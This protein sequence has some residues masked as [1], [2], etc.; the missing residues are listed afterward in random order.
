MKMKRFI[1]TL[2]SA[3]MLIS[4]LPVGAF[5][6]EPDTY[7][8]SDGS[9]KLVL[10]SKNGGFVIRTQEGDKLVKSDDNK[11]LLF[12]RDDYDTSFTSFRVTRQ[13]GSYQDYIFGGD[14]GFLGLASSGVTT[15]QDE[16]GLTSVW[17]VDDMTFTQRLELAGQGANEHGAVLLSY[18]AETTSAQPVDVK[19]RLLLDTALGEKDYAYYEV[20]NEFSQYRTIEMETVLTAADHIPQN[21]LGY[22]DPQNP[23]IT[24]YHINVDKAPYQV[25]FGHWNSLGASLF[26]FTPDNSLTF[27]NVYNGKY[28]TADSAVGLY[29]DMGQVTSSA[30]GTCGTYYGVYSNK[31]VADSETIAVNVTAPA[32]LELSA[33][34]KSYL[35]QKDGLLSGVFEMQAQMFNFPS[36]TAKEYDRVT[37]AI[38][39]S[40]GI[41][42]LDIDGN[43]HGT[44]TYLEPFTVDYNGFVVDQ[45]HTGTFRFKAD[46][47]ETSEFRKIELRVFDTSF[48]KTLTT[49]KIIGTKSFYVLCP[50]GDGKLPEVVFTNMSPKIVYNEGQRNLYL[51]G[52]NFGLL[53]DE[54]KYDVRAYSTSDPNLVYDIPDS[55]VEFSQQEGVDTMAVM[56]RETMQPGSYELRFNWLSDPP[57]GVQKDMTAPA[58]S[59]TV[60]EE[61]QYK[62]NYYGIL[63]VAQVGTGGNAEYKI[64]LY[65]TEDEFEKDK[66]NYE[67]ILLTFKGDFEETEEGGKTLYKATS[68]KNNGKAENVVVINDCM[69]FENGVM[70]VRYDNNFDSVLVDFDGDIYTSVKRSKIWSGEASF[71]ELRNNNEYGLVPYNSDGERMEGHFGEPITL[72]WPCGLGIAQSIS[73]MAFNL[74]FGSMGIV[75]DINGKNLSQVTDQTSVLGK[76]VSFSASLDLSFLVPNAGRSSKDTNWASIA[77][78]FGSEMTS[79]ELRNKWTGVNMLKHT[80]NGLN[81]YDNRTKEPQGSV[82]IQ[83][84]LYGCGKGLM[85]LNFDVDLV[86]PGYFDAM[87]SIIGH[88]SVNTI[89]GYE[90][91]AEGIC[92]FGTLEV[93]A[94]INIKDYEGK[95]IPDKLYFAIMGFEPGINVDG[96]G[97]LWITGGGGGID[98]LYDTIFGGSSVP[99]LK[100]LLTVSFD[101]LK[102]MSAKVDL[103]LSLRGLSLSA[104]DVRVKYFDLKVLNRLQ[105]AF[106]WYPEF[107]F[108]ASVDANILSIIR[109]QGYI[110][111][112]N[113]DEYDAFVEFFIR[114]SVQIP[115]AIPIIGGID[116][117][118]ADLGANNEKIWGVVRALGAELGITYYWGGDVDFG[119]GKAVA[120]PSF[121]SL[122]GYEDVPVFYDEETGQTL[123]MRAGSNVN[124][125]AQAYI[126]GEDDGTPKL[127]GADRYIESKISRLAHRITL[128]AFNNVDAALVVSFQADSQEEA[129][130]QAQNITISGKT[131]TFYDKALQN[132][133]SAN[134]NLVYDS[135]N[136]TATVN[137][138]FSEASEFGRSYDMETSVPANLALYDINPMPS[139]NITNAGLSGNVLTVDWD[140]YNLIELDGALFMLTDDPSGSV[141]A[142]TYP[143]HDVSYLPEKTATITLPGDLPTGTYYLKAVYSKE[144]YVNNQI[145]FPTPIQYKNQHQP[146]APTK[147]EAVNGGNHMFD[148]TVDKSVQDDFD[149]Y[150]VNVYQNDASAG[151]VLTDINN[152]VFEKNVDGTMP[153]LEVG[154]Y[155]DIPETDEAGKL[156]GTSKKVGIAPDQEYQIGIK[157]YKS[158]LNGEGKEIGRVLS[159]EVLSHWVTLKAPTPPKVTI[160]N[161]TS[162]Q[163]LYR[164]Q[165]GVAE[166]IPFDTFATGDVTFHVSSDVAVSGTWTLNDSITESIT[167]GQDIV[168]ADLEDGDY[169]LTVKGED[170]DGDT[171]IVEKSFAV[172]TMPPVLLLTSPVNGGLFDTDGSIAITGVTDADAKLTI[173]VN[174]VLY[175]DG[176]TVSELGGTID[177][178]GV[179]T[180]KVPG[181]PAKSVQS[182]VVSAADAMM[183]VSDVRSAKVYN[184]GFAQIDSVSI[185]LDGRKYTS[186]NLPSGNGISGK[187]SLGVNTP[188][189]TFLL[190][191]DDLVDFS[192]Q[193]AEGSASV[194]ANHQLTIDAGSMGTITGRFYVA[195]V[196]QKA[197]K[198]GYTAAIQCSLSFGAEQNELLKD[199]KEVSVSAGTGGA[200]T[201]AGFYTPGDTVVLTA[202]AS[203]GYQFDKWRVTSQNLNLADDKATTISFTMPAE[204]VTLEAIF[205][206][207]SNP[208]NQANSSIRIEGAGELNGREG[209]IYSFNLP[210][211]ANGNNY[212]PYYYENGKKT[213]VR[214]S[215]EVNGRLYFIAPKNA[216]Y[217]LAE[218]KFM[219]QDIAG[220]WA[221]ENILY[222]VSRNIFAGISDTI[223]AP[224]ECMT[225]AMFVTVL[226]R[227]SGVYEDKSKASGFLDV[228]TGMWYTPYVAWAAENGI[229]DGYGDGHFG[230]NDLVTREQMCAIINRYL[231]Q[232]GYNISPSVEAMNFAD[233]AQISPWAKASVI[234]CQTRGLILGKDNGNFAPKDNTT[235][236]EVA[237]LMKRLVAKILE[238]K[239]R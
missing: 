147:V 192:V 134:A 150:I 206:R 111:V 61:K 98:K 158:I 167:S 109:G 146:T 5:A 39:T 100:I 96:F 2:L 78:Q 137:I 73:G 231:E 68:A 57:S 113:N 1:S 157:A 116:V 80:Y 118:G 74:T 55:Q 27:T 125:A 181:D 224:N 126:E 44:G 178:G 101:I 112:L 60:S 196:D 107:Y 92:Q 88:L 204:N 51:T 50:G 12:H 66:G 114:A 229:V 151:A 62:N 85:G 69:D 156:T 184:E 144:D 110:V 16:T 18:K 179:F 20:V 212:A 176:K 138:T 87:P 115:E 216:V 143:I 214:I 54:S 141:S 32:E 207:T 90:I 166:P 93:E 104:T 194:D 173:Y 168:F 165:E 36:D 233:E 191:E 97:V 124:L 225:R 71:S 148:L 219:F 22:N 121:P 43:P 188:T 19:A 230:P 10:S 190:S 70:T 102:I 199:K 222:S 84:I 129:K 189:G 38:Y 195:D 33:D 45:T 48:D 154:G 236:A 135:E 23:T 213:F 21:F 40:N 162:F 218:N 15:T 180:V 42:A 67:E 209:E 11:D 183:N 35:P 139:M 238:A 153:K 106:E 217:R 79:T 6:A 3:I 160:E 177:G 175:A 198:A 202:Q 182:V 169:R 30:A 29:Y 53:V 7:E 203:S 75:Y 237:T 201:G 232:Q 47:G 122:L 91:G 171:F 34:K 108:M 223:F 52:K 140:G 17:K 210:Q 13:D 25:A 142:A 4:L 86:L 14:Y 174:D 130:A 64:K 197:A 172:D 117:G 77:V 145:V 164:I 211:N 136:K 220:H 56:L 228:P 31:T 49:D 208:G 119:T 28:L 131:L 63:A 159:K 205:D 161:K 127:L 99:P 105:L 58:L 155:F 163:T 83:D 72:L 41:T 8:L 95:P 193:T 46:V 239:M 235:R 82:M 26:D 200:V 120:K 9:V 152:I 187:L 89:A 128:G 221:E 186:G 133:N 103:S 76:V 81:Y 215:G 234:Y 170:A 227:L 149:G 24:A 226:G 59:F 65:K 94:A 37:L 123:Y 132:E 185:Y